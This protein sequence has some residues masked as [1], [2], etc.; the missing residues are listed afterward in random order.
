MV[1]FRRREM[2]VSVA[3]LWHAGVADRLLG[4]LVCLS[5]LCMVAVTLAT[6]FLLEFMELKL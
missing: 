1:I 5:L 6:D 2:G 3:Q 4:A